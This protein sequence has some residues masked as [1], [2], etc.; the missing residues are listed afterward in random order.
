MQPVRSG[1]GVMLMLVARSGSL[2]RWLWALRGCCLFVEAGV[3]LRPSL[4]ARARIWRDARLGPR[5]WSRSP[6]ARS[7]GWGLDPA[8]TPPSSPMR[9]ALSALALIDLVID[10]RIAGRP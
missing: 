10:E 3:W 2:A 6:F 1:I 8:P 9:F 7:R 4:L 5:R